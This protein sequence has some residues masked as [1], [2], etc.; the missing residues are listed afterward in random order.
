MPRNLS[1]S[2]RLVAQLDNALKTLTPG[3]IQARQPLPGGDQQ[4]PALTTDQTQHIAGLMRI[5]HT[6]EVC[7]QGLYQGQALTAKLV[8]VRE[9]MEQAAEEE[10]DH[11][12][13]CEQRLTELNSR[14]SYLNPVFYGLSYVMGAAAGIAGDAWSLGFVAATEDQVSAH[15]RD[16]LRQIDQQDPRSTAIL[17]RMLADEERHA[18]HAL[19]AGGRDF[20]PLVKQAM[21]GISKVMTKTVYRV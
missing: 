11:L 15:L 10:L 18:E 6:G 16:H 3:A 5:N 21:T 19:A 1:F 7:A 17:E 12:A 2:D 13:W 4:A 20:P 9:D 14:T 8:Q